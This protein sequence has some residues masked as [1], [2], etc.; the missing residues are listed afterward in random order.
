[1]TPSFSGT[2][3]PLG[4]VT[5]DRPR[6]YQRYVTTLAGQRVSVTVTK[7][8]TQRSLKQNKWLHGPA[9]D[10][11]EPKFREL[12]D[13]LGNHL[14]YEKSEMK[15]VLLGECYGY[16]YNPIAKR[17]VPVKTHTSQLTTKEFAAFMEWL[18]DWAASQHGVYIGLP[19]DE[20]PVE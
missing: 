1:M 17:D 5:F 7:P 6:E 10:A 19:D 20:V 16:H 9:L 11:L 4:T 2:A 18:V 13:A 12:T 3:T 15:L 14:G 8:K